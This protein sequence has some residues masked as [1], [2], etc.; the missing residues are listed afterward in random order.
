[1]ARHDPLLPN[2]AIVARREYRDRVRSRL[3]LISTA[4]LMALALGVALSPI[5]LRYLDRSDVDRIL[6]VADEPRLATGTVATA[7][8]IMNIPPPGVDLATWTAP[9]AIEPALDR[10][11]AMRE[12]AAGEADALIDVTRNADGRLVVTYRTLGPPDGV[13]AQLAG[14][15][16]LS[17]AILDWTSSLPPESQLG[18]FRTPEFSTEA[19]SGPVEGGQAVDA[20][21]V[22]S[23]AF[24]GTVFI[25]LMFISIL[26]YGMWVATGVATEK[27]SRVMELMISAA[28]P[29]QL[30][31]GKVVGIGAAGLTQYLAISVPAVAVLAFQEPI[32]RAVLGD[33]G[34]GLPIGGLTIGLLAAYGLFFLLGFVLFALIYAATG[35]FVSRPDDLQTLSLPLSLVAMAGYLSAIVILLGANGTLAAIASFLPP[36]SP[37]AMLAR[38]MVGTVQPWELVLSV[39]IL[40][41]TIAVV[42]LATVRIYATG[43]L[44][45]GQRPGLRRFLAAARRAG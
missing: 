37:F 18:E 44:L 16:A 23:R 11:T 7:N 33:A 32:A 24:L 31:L 35:S 38:L 40:V 10:A 43:V 3:F 5:G 13:R 1:M 34:A 36:L 8:G 21:L 20:V 17:V 14:F 26:I 6:V 19:I 41:A 29:R 28:S 39:A 12:L 4:I 27:S 30:L 9:F 42:A 15:A 45:Y 22:A 2:A 25:I